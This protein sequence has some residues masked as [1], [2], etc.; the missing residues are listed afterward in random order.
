MV[1]SLQKYAL[2]TG[3]SS[4]IGRATALALAQAG[5]DLAVV[6]RSKEA[7]DQVADEAR[8]H[9]V[10]VEVFPFDLSRVDDVRSTIET[11]IQTC[12]AIDVLINNAGMGYTGRLDEMSLSDWQ[13]VMDLNLTSPFLC[14]QAILP[15]MRDRHQGT[16]VN[17]ASIAGYQAFPEWGAYS[18]SKAG[19]IML[20]KAFATESRD[21]GVRVV[22]LSP[23]AVNTPIWD[24][25]TVHADFD[26]S[27]MLTPDIVAQAIVHCV[28]LPQHAVIEDIKIMP[29]G[30]AL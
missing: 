29:G 26:R 12:G 16:I 13:H 23:G 9:G 22:T 6:S 10:S 17:I 2:I 1:G 14:T 28:T 15:H 8:T 24:S 11:I 25:D 20:S 18:V 4:G 19:M 5:F 7:L 27:K 30:G 21:D 3:A